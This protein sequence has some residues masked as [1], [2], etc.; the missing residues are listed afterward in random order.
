MG[1]WVGAKVLELADDDTITKLGDAAW[2]DIVEHDAQVIQ[3]VLAALVEAVFVDA[4]SD[5]A[6]AGVHE[7]A[8]ST[9]LA[10]SC[11]QVVDLWLLWH[12]VHH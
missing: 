12:V 2:L 5:V 8:R 9:G 1:P 6:L 3:V 10:G 4:S 7:A 11:H